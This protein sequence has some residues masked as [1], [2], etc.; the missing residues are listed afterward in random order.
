MTGASSGTGQGQGGQGTASGRGDSTETGDR[1]APTIWLPGGASDIQRVDGAS[2]TSGQ[3]EIVGQGQGI[4]G[5]SGARVPV[6]EVLGS[7]LDEAV[8]SLDRGEVPPA[9]R[10]LVQRYF[11]AIAGF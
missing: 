1:S 11:D 8:E 10:A 6:G 7:Y 3:S 5:A 4:T 9:A 2:T